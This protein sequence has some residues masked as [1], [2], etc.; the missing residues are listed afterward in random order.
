MTAS[1]AAVASPR[2]LH[3]YDSALSINASTVSGCVLSVSVVR[4]LALCMRNRKLSKA[5]VSLLKPEPR[6]R[7]AADSVLHSVRTLPCH[8]LRY[9]RLKLHD[10]DTKPLHCSAKQNHHYSRGSVLLFFVSLFLVWDSE[11]S[12][13]NSSFL[14][15]HS[16]GRRMLYPGSVG[17]LQKAM[18]ATLQQGQARLIE[19]VR[20][21]ARPL[22]T[23]RL[24]CIENNR[25]LLAL[26]LTA[27]GTNWWL[28]T[29]MRSTRCSWTGG[30]MWDPTARPW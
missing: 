11:F 13:S 24:H 9:S 6:L 5:G 12:N 4:P 14:I 17:L 28:V 16:F 30:E 29:E 7:G 20:L 10:P 8:I 23:T 18:R 15:A 3:Y 19:E 22:Y 25:F 27:R 26:S 21:Q 1:F 2:S